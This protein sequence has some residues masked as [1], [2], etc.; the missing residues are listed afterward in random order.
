MKFSVC[1]TTQRSSQACRVLSIAALTL[2]AGLPLIAQRALSTYQRITGA[3][4]KSALVY[5]GKP[6]HLKMDVVLPG[7]TGTPD[8]TATVERWQSGDDS[9]TIEAFGNGA[10]TLLEQNGKSYSL[11]QGEAIPD[12]VNAALLQVLHPGPYP[13]DLAGTSPDQRR[14]PFGKISLDC[15]M[16]SRPM[17]RVAFAPLGLFPTYCLNDADQIAASY[18]FG[19]QTMVQE[20]RG[21]FL[22]HEISVGFALLE[23]SKI[24]ARAKV[25][26]LSVF[27]PAPNEFDPTPELVASAMDVQI[28]GA[29]ME[30][31][32]TKK[33]QPIY[34]V[35]A[36][37]ARIS[38]TVVLAARIG[39][40]GR[41]YSIRPVSAPDPDLTVAAIAAV[42]QW[43]YKPYLLQGVPTEVQTTV[44]VNFNLRPF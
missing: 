4:D 42:R 25:T 3:T 30:G 15:I 32:I 14:Q 26:T 13:A 8:A 41:V 35:S 7:G 21:R 1:C 44:T 9:K 43:T 5:V 37:Q 29:V 17:K 10:R 19:S 40:D 22:D 31:S 27:P 33:V 24:V 12:L 39:T 18:N 16:L 11:S 34:P 2:L 38:G 23:G 6:F 36:R 20:T 28:S